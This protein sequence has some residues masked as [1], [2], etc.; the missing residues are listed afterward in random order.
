MWSL[1]NHFAVVESK[2]TKLKQTKKAKH[3]ET[4]AECSSMAGPRPDGGAALP[5]QSLRA[6]ALRPPF[7]GLGRAAARQSIPPGP[8]IFPLLL[9]PPPL[10]PP[11]RSSQHAPRGP[12]AAPRPLP[13]Q[14][15][16]G[17]VVP[18]CSLT[19][20]APGG[21]SPAG[22]CATELAGRVSGG[23]SAFGVGAAVSQPAGR[24]ASGSSAPLSGEGPRR[25]RERGS[26]NRLRQG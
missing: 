8:G 19:A 26:V 20:E 4:T 6:P 7:R 14:R 12:A 16:P 21:S 13:Q 24:R 9:R 2:H 11:D 22:C 15:P 10:P 3:L 18:G 25:W 1:G 23:L 17:A 5:A